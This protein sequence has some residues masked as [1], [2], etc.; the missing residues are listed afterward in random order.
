MKCINEEKAKLYE[1]P[2][3]SVI[4]ISECDVITGSD[5]WALPIMPFGNDDDRPGNIEYG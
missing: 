1:M 3:C 2:D 4:D 5:D